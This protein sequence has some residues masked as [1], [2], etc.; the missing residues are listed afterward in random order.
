MYLDTVNIWNWRKFGERDSGEP[1]MTVTFNP[2]LNVIVGENDSG[3]TT[4]I[5][6]VKLGLNTNSQDSLWIKETDFHDSDKPIK[7]EYVFKNLSEDEEAFFFEWIYFREGISYLRIF[8]IAEQQLDVN[9]KSKITKSISGGEEGRELPLSDSVKQLLTVTYLKPLRDAEL[10]LSPGNRSRFAQILKNLSYFR[11]DSGASKTEIEGILSSAFSDIQS[12]IDKPVLEKMNE[13]IKAFFEKNRTK[14]PEIKPKHMKFEEALRKLELNLGD[15]GS[16]L[17]SSNLLFMAAELILL[18]DNTIGAKIALIEEIEAHIHPQAQLRL[19]KYFERKSKEE[20]IQYILTSHS[21]ILASSISL[22]HLILIYNNMAY[23]MRAGLTRLENGDYKF[24]ERF[25]D[26][27]KSNMFF[28][29]GIIFVEGDA[30]NLLMP[31]LAEVIDRPLHDYGVSIINVGNL[32]FK[33]YTLIFLRKF[34]PNLN[35]PVSIV[36]DLDLKPVSYYGD[37]ICYF[38]VDQT[39]E[40]EI[41]K[42]IVFE[43]EET[44]IGIYTRFNVLIKKL[45]RI[46][47]KDVKP[48][49]IE[50][51]HTYLQRK[52][53]LKFNDMLNNKESAIQTNLLHTIEKTKVFISKPWTLEF[54]IAEST[55]S[56]LLQEAILEA[57]YKEEKNRETVKNEW[58]KIENA[59]ERAVHIYQFM[60]DLDISKAVVSQLLSEKIINNKSELALT[61]E[62]DPKLKY[63]IDA[64][65]HATGG[66]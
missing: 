56:D 27:T 66:V 22:E 41:K 53:K 25:L 28:A 13:I 55:L 58:A 51:L 47:K 7:I 62:N 36:T 40:Q 15:V 29:Q 21:P 17:G 2:H 39:D 59:E 34:E 33:R 26:A 8:L 46:L 9:L 44:L 65:K 64:I 37:E 10:E 45:S 6:A 54:A 57:N 43:S 52:D 11:N 12:I 20:G 1:G 18:S 19:I 30:E 42:I 4:I 31:T 5:D 3:K 50:A 61:I 48:D 24:L 63:L 35:F 14:N 49:E 16:G 38:E 23:P 32:A 60:L